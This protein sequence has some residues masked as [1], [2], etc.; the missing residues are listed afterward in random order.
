MRTRNPPS[1]RPSKLRATFFALLTIP[2]LLIGATMNNDA[3]ANQ[4]ITA[5]NIRQFVTEGFVE[6]D[7]VKIHYAALGQGPLV[8]LIHGHPDFWYGWRNQMPALAQKYQVVAIDQRGFHKSD[9]PKG[10]EH[11][12]IQKEIS[13]VAA[14]IKQFKREKA[15]LVGH[16]TG[17]SIAWTFAS[18][19]PQMTAGVVSLNL[20]HPIAFAKA[21]ASDPGQQAAS[22]T[23]FGLA[24]PG[25]AAALTREQLLSVINP[26]DPNDRQAYIEAF[27][28]TDL[29]TFV[30]YF[31]AN[32]G[33]SAPKGATL[34]K[35]SVPALVIHGMKDPFILSSSHEHNWEYTDNTLTTVMIPN[36]GHFVQNDA[37]VEVTRQ[38]LNFMATIN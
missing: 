15:I 37:A 33:P 38:L 14:V 24:R 19:L 28:Q 26:S 13:D 3:H 30:A 36:A 32:L 18:V 17:A 31:Q 20:P 21:R 27:A 2:A 1:I 23:S 22:R 7:S 4:T 16:D 8:I 10:P 6:N 34:P 12:T 29:E 5:E 9:Q 11:Y 35:L 25:S